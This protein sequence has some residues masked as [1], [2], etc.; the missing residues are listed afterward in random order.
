MIDSMQFIDY[1]I[2]A[3]VAMSLL[4]FFIQSGKEILSRQLMPLDYLLK[5]ENNILE[6]NS[7]LKEQNTLIKE[8]N[9][10]LKKLVKVW[11]KND[12]Q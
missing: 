3:V 1:G 2:I 5:V 4:F 8:Q 7:L 9:E 6:Q 10:L 11:V 12:N